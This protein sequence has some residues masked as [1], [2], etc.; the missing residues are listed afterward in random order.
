ML[1]SQT[2]PFGGN[3]GTPFGVFKSNVLCRLSTK[4]EKSFMN[5]IWCIAR[6]AQS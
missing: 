4:Q 3:T 2:Q 6:L 5:L 1:S